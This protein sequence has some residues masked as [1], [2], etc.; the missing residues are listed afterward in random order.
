MEYEW[1]ESKCKANIV[2][3][4][5][6]FIAAE[7]FDWSTAIEAFDNRINYNEERWVAL[8]FI[9]D[10][11]YILVYTQRSDSIRII[12]LRKANKREREFYETQ[13]K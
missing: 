13:T 3:H 8:G 6:D 4:G 11:L 5:V 2:K 10:H 1:D 9:S 12:S 7:E